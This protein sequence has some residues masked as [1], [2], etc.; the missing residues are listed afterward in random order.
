MWCWHPIHKDQHDQLFTRVPCGSRVQRA[1]L[2]LSIR[3]LYPVPKNA[4]LLF[5][6]QP[7]NFTAQISG[8]NNATGV[9]L[10]EIFEL[11]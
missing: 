5:T 7:G 11:P 8:V 6:F 3:T 9:A 10:V 2:T 4:A 1:S